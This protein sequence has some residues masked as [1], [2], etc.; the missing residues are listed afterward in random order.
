MSVN[1]LPDS[2]TALEWWWVC[3]A[4]QHEASPDR[5]ANDGRTLICTCGAD[6]GVADGE[7]L[8]GLSLRST[9]R[10]AVTGDALHRPQRTSGEALSAEL[11]CGRLQRC[12]RDAHKGLGY[13]S[14]Q[15]CQSPKPTLPRLCGLLS[16]CARS[17]SAW[18]L[19]LKK[20]RCWGSRASISSCST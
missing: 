14:C 6:A 10:P 15:G 7:M 9:V 2:A 1:L 5:P 11:A 4:A 19:M 18:V 17:S 16:L 8:R 3:L 20:E 13:G 12:P